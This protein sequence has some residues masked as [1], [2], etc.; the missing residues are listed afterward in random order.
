MRKTLSEFKPK[1]PY[2]ICVD[3]DGCAIDSM[4]IKHRTCFGPC[5]VTEW[6][7]DTIKD[8]FLVRWNEINLYSPTRG[9]NR[10]KGLSLILEEFKLQGWEEIKE[11]TERTEALSN[12]ALKLE[13]SPAL[14]KIL[15]WSYR[16][17]KA[18]ESL[19]LP[20]PFLNVKETLHVLSKQ[21]DIVVVSSANLRAIEKEWNDGSILDYVSVLMSQDNGSKKVC[22]ANLLQKG[23]DREKV[24]MIG[25][26]PGDKQAAEENEVH[27]YPIIPGD[28]SKSWQLLKEQVW[29]EF[30]D[31]KLNDS[32]IKEFCLKL[33]L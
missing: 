17:N 22:I 21:A 19:P 23:Y 14:K 11:W 7:L 24:L 32:Y 15:D 31:Q 33:G 25:D 16:V 27:Y 30:I 8:D 3:S 13:T 9:I 4:E 12:D 5:A 2:L 20:T 28:E 10:F 6:G 1:Y 29:N 18:I 26:A